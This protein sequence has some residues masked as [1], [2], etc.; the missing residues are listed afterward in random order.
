MTRVADEMPPTAASLAPGRNLTAVF[1]NPGLPGER[2]WNMVTATMQAAARDLNVSLEV[3]YAERNPILMKRLASAA[4]ARATPPDYLVLVNEEQAASDLLPLADGG[5]SH[6]VML[7]NGLTP[8][9]QTTHG[10]PGSVHPSW[11]ASVIPDNHGAGRRMA[12][13]LIDAARIYP[14]G[15]TRHGLAL[16]GDTRT[17]AS[18]ARNA[19]MLNGFAE[20]DAIKMTRILEARWNLPDAERLTHHYLQWAERSGLHNTLIWAAN[21][22][23]AEGAVRAV[24]ASG[25]QPGKDVL[26][27]GLNW[28]PEG[29]A[30]VMDKRMVMSDG[31]HFMAGAWAMVMLRDHA[32]DTHWAPRTVHFPMSPIHQGNVDIYGPLLIQ[33]DWE[34]VDFTRFRLQTMEDDYAFDPMAV[35]EQM[36][37]LPAPLERQD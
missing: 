14:P 28:S 10:V 4:L 23:M 25:M 21:D 30:M 7:L 18:I 1:V 15:E 27:A 3:V 33:P 36:K 34:T 2:F 24:E 9:E 13:E 17:P 11:I 16:I 5:S 22:A 12:S 35:L 20:H 19:G 31:G 8:E 29:I 37:D 26:I 32:D 6:I